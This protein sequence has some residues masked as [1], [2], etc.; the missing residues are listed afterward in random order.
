[1]EILNAI[2]SKFCS[3]FTSPAED[4]SSSHPLSNMPPQYQSQALPRTSPPTKRD[5]TSLRDQ[6]PNFKGK[7]PAYGY[8]NIHDVNF[9]D[10]HS[11]IGTSSFV[12]ASEGR[13]RSVMGGGSLGSRSHTGGSVYAS[14]KGP[15]S[16]R[17]RFDNI[18]GYQ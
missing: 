12:T 6:A 18:C 16:W 17:G 10:G 9:C 5:F 7:N 11:S 4:E 3:C 13:G 14:V 1:M 8:T 2:L 15:S